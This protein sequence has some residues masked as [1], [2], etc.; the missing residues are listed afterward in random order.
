MNP[1][2]NPEGVKSVKR[3]QE[4]LF[5]FTGRSPFGRPLSSSHAAAMCNGVDL[6][7]NA[8]RHLCRLFLCAKESAFLAVR[9]LTYDMQI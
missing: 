1:S 4:P 5:G 6:I 2:P 9:K 7:D 3:C 8:S